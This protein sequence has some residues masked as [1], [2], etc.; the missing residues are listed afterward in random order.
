[1]ASQDNDKT[2]AAETEQQSTSREQ[3]DLGEVEELAGG[4]G[5]YNKPI[6]LPEI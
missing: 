4:K 1:M 2:K 3:L 6:K 5:D